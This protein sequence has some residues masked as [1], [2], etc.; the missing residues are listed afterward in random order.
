MF[1]IAGTS[2]STT[3]T[4]TVPNVLNASACQIDSIIHSQSGATHGS[5]M[6]IIPPGSST[7][8]CV[9]NVS[10]GA[11]T[12]SGTKQVKGQFMLEK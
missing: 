5:G 12:A 6:A 4:F 2:N 9:F 11:W 8:T 1:N 10:S 7:V 3:L